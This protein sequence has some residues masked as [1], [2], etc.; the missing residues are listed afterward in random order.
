M[1]SMIV[2]VGMRW[3]CTVEGVERNDPSMANWA[4]R[5]AGVE[6]RRNLRDLAVEGDEPVDVNPE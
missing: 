5:A 1:L 2:S 3:K 4:D 6:F